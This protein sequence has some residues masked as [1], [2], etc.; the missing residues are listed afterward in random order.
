VSSVDYLALGDFVVAGSVPVTTTDRDLAWLGSLC[1]RNAEPQYA[2]LIGGFDA[3]GV[4]ILTENQLAAEYSAWPLSGEHLAIRIDGWTFGTNSHYVA[5]DVEV[6][7][8][9]VDAR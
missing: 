4:Q 7:R 9:P 1:D 8:V 3:V 2:L 5:F 6:Q